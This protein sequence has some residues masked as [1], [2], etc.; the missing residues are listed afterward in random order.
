MSHLLADTEE[1]LLAMADTIGVNRRWY[2]IP[3]A[4]TPRRVPHFDVCDA[5]R[6]AALLAGAVHL[7]DNAA[8][9]A[10]LKRVREAI[11]NGTFYRKNGGSL[12]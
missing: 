7:P 6:A 10:L 12:A 8:V 11:Q 2:Q 4:K 3:D 5:K 9:A 1:E